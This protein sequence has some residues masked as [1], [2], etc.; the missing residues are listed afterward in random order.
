[1]AVSQKGGGVRQLTW[2]LAWAVVFCDIGTSVYYVPGILYDR[3]GIGSL[4]PFFIVLTAAGFVLLALKYVEIVERTPQGGGVV[5][6]GHMAFGERMGALGG[7]F[8]T[9]DFFLTCAISSVAAFYY[10]ASAN[11]ALA[12]TAAAPFLL[13]LGN[14]VPL[15]A[16]AGLLLLGVVNTIGLRESA[17]L[18][19]VMASASLVT[20]IAVVVV[21]AADLGLDMERWR[22]LAGAVFD[23][24]GDLGRQ[25]MLIG[26][27]AAWLAFSGLETMSQ[28]A[29]VIREPLRRTARMTMV[30]VVV[31][32]L[33]TSPTLAVLSVGLLP[34]AGGEV[35]SE[36]LISQLAFV[37][38][39]SLLGMAVVVTAASLLLF[40]ANTAIIGAYHV[41]VAL[42]ER[43]YFPNRMRRRHKRFKTPYL[44]IRLATLVPIGVIWA[45]QG[46]LGLLGDMYAFGL[47]GAFIIESG[48]L[49]VLRWREG[50]RDLSFW[51][52]ILPTVMVVTA[53][54]VNI[55]EKPEATLFGGTLA[56][57]GML[58]GTG[59]RRGWIKDAFHTLPG[60]A[61]DDV[62]K[63]TA[64]ERVASE[65]IHDIITLAEAREVIPFVKSST[66]VA[67]SG[68]N[69]DVIAEGIRRAKGMGESALYCIFV[70]EWPGLFP[71][72]EGVMPSQGGIKTLVGA[73]VQA[74][75][76]GVEMVPIW[77]ASH[78]AALG[79][80]HAVDELGVGGV[81]IGSPTRAAMNRLLR[82]QVI[83]KLQRLL[84]ESC[85]LVICD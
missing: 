15:Y 80:A 75:E 83:R 24:V 22:A 44:A 6:I 78:N 53:W 9:V 41:F 63:I 2:L 81:I 1:M 11:D 48:G 55:A 76:A 65:E 49:D 36:R 16:M 62:A 34:T 35:E 51:F 31:T 30:S 85:R 79:I 58:V 38:G 43:R 60:V 74:A 59:L 5:A 54:F 12:G 25:E 70:E 13:H 56:A 28:L 42:S 64:G 52:G 40:A 4:A 72:E 18:S 47:L 26:F 37:E 14:N 57:I 71:S 50:R 77:T 3:E 10:L 67:V 8:I 61:K 73:S 17:A 32:V 33:L 39:G 69:P 66:L 19:L 7:M 84:P 23:G 27:G 82:G 46:E 21:T 29:P 20:N 68:P 45:T